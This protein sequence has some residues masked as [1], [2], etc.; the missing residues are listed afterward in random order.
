YDIVP[1]TEWPS[2]SL[3]GGFVDT[4]TTATFTSVADRSWGYPASTTATTGSFTPVDES[5]Y[6][7]DT[8]YDVFVSPSWAT[9]WHVT[10]KATSGFTINFGTA[11]SSG[12]ET[13]AWM[14]VGF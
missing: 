9:T 14:L 8:N 13:V 2:L 7:P 10:A 3:G 6:E 12:A 1:T 11:A 4:G 5:G